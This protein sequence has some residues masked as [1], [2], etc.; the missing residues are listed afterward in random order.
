M[1]ELTSIQ[2]LTEALTEEMKRDEQVFA[3]G[4]AVGKLPAQWLELAEKFGETRVRDTPISEEVIVGA[5][6]GAALRGMRPV[7]HTG[8]CDYLNYLDLLV[9]YA[10]KA[11]FMSA[12]KLKCPIV[13]KPIVGRGRNAGPHHS[14]DLT[15]WFMHIPG[16]KVVVPSTPYDTKGL[17]KT[18]IRDDNPVLFMEHL[19]LMR[20][21]GSVPEREYTIPF[22]KA[23]VKR[24][25]KD[26]TL[27]A[28]GYQ[29]V[30]AMV[31]AEK[32]AKDGINAEV[33]DL[34]TLVPLDKKTILSSVSKTGRLVTV[35]E[36]NQNCGVGAEISAIVASEGFEYLKASIVRVA[37][38]NAIIPSNPTLAAQIIPDAE[39]ICKA[40]HM[41]I[42]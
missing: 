38:P 35:E 14:Q 36:G 39:K 25:G 2:A 30:E 9:N 28:V 13:I 31:A 12:G 15:A 33:I 11:R 8:F 16:I 20:M 29:V 34:R 42:R 21:K 7:I 22:G 10:A 32:L 41:I 19:L 5:G 18:A 27:V 1:R 23:K 24:E 17:F 6:V 37:L 26:V 3:M 40:V 4:V